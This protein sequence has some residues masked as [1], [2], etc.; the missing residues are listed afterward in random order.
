MRGKVKGPKISIWIAFMCVFLSMSESCLIFE[1][2]SNWWS[3]LPSYDRHLTEPLWIRQNWIFMPFVINLAVFVVCCII[4]VHF[5]IQMISIKCF[6]TFAYA[7]KRKK[8]MKTRWKTEC[9]M[10]SL[11]LMINP[12]LSLSWTSANV[13]AS[14][15]LVVSVFRSHAFCKCL[16]VVCVANHL[17]WQRLLVCSMRLLCA[18]NGRSKLSWKPWNWISWTIL[19]R[20]MPYSDKRFFYYVLVC[21]FVFSFC[22]HFLLALLHLAT[23]WLP[24]FIIWFAQASW[25]H[26]K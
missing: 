12:L 21:L 2:I 7:P 19:S 18:C 3:S 11:K 26:L 9:A 10:L 23:K 17:C 1:W 13:C 16:L 24:F 8:K 22:S 15:K 20:L 5:L 4:N 25:I 14:D 6:V